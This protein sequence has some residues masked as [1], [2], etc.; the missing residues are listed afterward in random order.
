[1][2][3]VIGVIAGCAMVACAHGSMSSPGGGPG[4]DD[5]GGG[6]GGGGGGSSVSDAG[7]DSGGG[8]GSGS[9]G[10][11]AGATLSIAT[12]TSDLLILNGAA[13]HATFTAT[14]TALDGTTRD[15][16]AET[17]FSIDHNFGGFAGNE[18]TITV[19]VRTQVIGQRRNKVAGADVVARLKSVRNELPIDPTSLFAAPESAALAPT[20]KYPSPGTVMPRN[21]GDFEIHW[22]DDHGHD[23]F[24][25]SLTT[26]LTDVRVYLAGG[27][28]DPMQG[29]MP[30]SGAF[31]ADEWFAAVGVAGAVT[32]RVRGVNTAAPGMVG[33]MPPQTVQLSN[34]IMDGGLYYWAAASTT[35]VTGIFRHDMNRP[36]LKAEEFLTTNQTGGR[37]VACHVLSRD[38]TKMTVT[39]DAV[40]A[41][42]ATVVD[43]A[44]RARAPE[45]AAWSFATFTPD[46]TQLLAVEHGVLKVRDATTQAELATMP[47]FPGLDFWVTQPDLSPVGTQ[48]VYVH[49]SLF[50]PDDTQFKRGLIYVRNY[51]PATHEFGVEKKLVDDGVNNFSPRWSPDGNW[52]AF[53]RSPAADFSYDDN[54]ASTWVVKADGSASPIELASADAVAG[55]TNSEVRWAPFPQTLG[56]ANE[57][58]FWLTMSSKR[59]FGVRLKN[60]GL[61]QR[62]KRAQLWM[63]PFFPSRAAQGLDPSVPAFRLPFQDLSSSNHTAQWTQRIVGSN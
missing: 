1:M 60:N 61:A 63:T 4:D 14:L 20:L 31:R 35:N 46:N 50:G 38:G 2:K 13:A 62:A 37:C 27:N 59:D 30:S 3:I 29:T 18:L 32:Y 8:D 11:P 6:G 53:N 43:V 9:G 12:Q 28:G 16:T 55:V 52:I 51:N 23:A 19:A 48:L 41:G 58:M 56:A 36:G 44:T 24:E 5:G 45:V 25:I 33:A 22:T 42:P 34:E 54:N 21:L 39:F 26:E 17:V 47:T 7:V 10:D 57:Q 40:D 49:A 15:V